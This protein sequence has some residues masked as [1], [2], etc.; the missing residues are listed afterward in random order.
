MWI[1]SVVK[2]IADVYAVS[3]FQRRFITEPTKNIGI[4]MN[5]FEF[6][7]VCSTVANMAFIWI[8]CDGLPLLFNE[9]P[10]NQDDWQQKRNLTIILATEHILLC[11]K[12]VLSTMIPDVPEHV[13]A[14]MTERS[15]RRDRQKKKTK[16]KEILMDRKILNQE[17]QKYNSV[18]SSINLSNN[19]VSGSKLL[20]SKPPTDPSSIKLSIDQP[21]LKSKMDD[22]TKTSN[23]KENVQEF[24]EAENGQ[25]FTEI[26]ESRS[27]S[28]HGSKNL[29]ED[30]FIVETLNE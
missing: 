12:F 22:K 27:H 26:K 9:D 17:K 4:W 11:I 10:D 2:L 1:L 5:I 25:E 13:E 28:K 6:L 29:S 19:N 14:R 8:A 21:N 3:F 20:F 16:D 18:M 15:Y 7:S 23:F 24:T 30:A